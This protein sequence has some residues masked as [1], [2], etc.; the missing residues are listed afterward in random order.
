MLTL[1]SADRPRDEWSESMRFGW[2]LAE[3]SFGI[4]EPPP[5][6][7]ASGAEFSEWTDRALKSWLERKSHTVEAARR[8][9]DAAADEDERQRIMAGA[10]VGLMYEDVARVLRTL[11]MPAELEQE[12][13]IAEVYREV[14]EAQAS[15][16]LEHARRAYRACAA[17]AEKG[18]SS[19]GHWMTYCRKRLSQMPF[20]AQS[21]VPPGPSP[22]P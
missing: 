1:P 17:N 5:P 2:A 4:E 7:D 18:P 6:G 3:E 12:P 11:P 20:P 14:I 19:M 10:V 16:F 21:S 15:P 22:T 8:E 9:L 13:D